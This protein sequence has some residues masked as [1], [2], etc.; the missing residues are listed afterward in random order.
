MFFISSVN[1]KTDLCQVF[2][3]TIPAYLYDTVLWIM[4]KKQFMVRLIKR[5]HKGVRVVEYFSV[6]EWE[7]EQNN[8]N[9]LKAD[10]S[11]TDQKTFNFDVS[12]IDW[13][14]YLEDY[15]KG[16][17]QYFF[18]EDL[19][20]LEQ[21]RRHQNNMFWLDKIFQTFCYYILFKLLVWLFW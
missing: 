1:D 6:N 21:A 18:K 9:Q 8:I 10:I 2:Q 19:S 12:L 5:L 15:I 14:K 16:T 11:H 20:S 13:D 17:R 3:H 4:G 7:W